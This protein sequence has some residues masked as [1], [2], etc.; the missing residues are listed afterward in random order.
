MRTLKKRVLSV[1]IIVLLILSVNT[2][3]KLLSIPVFASS[4]TVQVATGYH[5]VLLLKRDG[6]VWTWG[7][8]GY[9]QLCDGTTES[10]DTPMKVEGLENVIYIACGN[11]HSLAVKR[12]GTVW[13]WGNNDNGQLGDGS[14][15]RRFKPVQVRNINNVKSVA[16]GS[17]H[18]LA[19]KND[20]T[21]WAW[22]YNGY[23]QYELEIHLTAVILN[24]LCQMLNLLQQDI[25]TV[26][27]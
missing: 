15:T 1:L 14:T 12:D 10:R 27:L 7:Y 13:T 23:G 20:G 16:G 22:G 4:S 6:T 5:H 21:V 26:W 19:L 11:Y 17:D 3:S 18:S 25:T 2:D 9:G 24:K 8:N